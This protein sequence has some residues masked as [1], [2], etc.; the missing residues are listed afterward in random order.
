MGGLAVDVEVY[1]ARHIMVLLVGLGNAERHR[2]SFASS[3][4]P[5]TSSPSSATLFAI[6]S[7]CKSHSDHVGRLLFFWSGFPL[8]TAIPPIL[9]W[10]GH[11]RQGAARIFI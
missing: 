9:S 10:D 11:C 4:L 7:S 5:M 2:G 8:C 1:E 3:L 6:T